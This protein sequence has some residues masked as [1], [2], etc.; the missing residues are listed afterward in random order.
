MLWGWAMSHGSGALC[1]VFGGHFPPALETEAA[2]FH[3]GCFPLAPA[4]GSWHCLGGE[5]SSCLLRTG[6]RTRPGTAGHGSPAPP[7]ASGPVGG[8]ARGGWREGL[9]G[10]SGRRCHC[11][12]IWPGRRRGEREGEEEPGTP[13]TGDSPRLPHTCALP[14]GPFGQPLPQ[15][16]RHLLPQGAGSP[17]PFPS[18]QGNPDVWAQLR[19]CSALLPCQMFPLPLG[20]GVCSPAGDTKEGDGVPPVPAPPQGLLPHPQ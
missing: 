8:S 16:P 9:G 15:P 5:G 3:L 10:L 13:G 12:G 7:R 1:C 19:H 20:R 2:V 14:A 17:L 18:F 6:L 4:A 11:R